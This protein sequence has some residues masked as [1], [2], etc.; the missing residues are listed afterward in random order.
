MLRSFK[1][2][3]A[4]AVL[5]LILSL[6]SLG[7][8]PPVRVKAGDKIAHFLAYASLTLTL[9]LEYAVFN[10]WLRQPARWLIYPVVFA[11]LYG[12]L[13]EFLQ[14]SSLSQRNFD[15]AD[16]L[17]NFLGSVAAALLFVVLFKPLK[18]FFT[19]SY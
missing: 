4:L 14:A 18:K 1:L 12:V 11:S 9:L 19:R 3:L 8:V 6:I 15:Y 16:M 13:M 7:E 17:A 10:R 2:T 5:I